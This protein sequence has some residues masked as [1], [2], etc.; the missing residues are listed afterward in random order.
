[1][2]QISVKVRKDIGDPG[3]HQKYGALKPGTTITIEE[4][5]FGVGLFERPTPEWL[6]P[7]ELADKT[8]GEELKCSV[9]TFEYVEPAPAPEVLAKSKNSA[10]AA[11]KPEPEV[12]NA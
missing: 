10:T 7:H 3:R 8:R 5:D 11:S 4:E 9:G 2:S 6:S 1:M 12:I